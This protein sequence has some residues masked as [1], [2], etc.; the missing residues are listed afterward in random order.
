MRR[1]RKKKK[2][3]LRRKP[4]KILVS[5]LESLRETKKIDLQKTKGFKKKKKPKRR[6]KIKILNSF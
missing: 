3:K 1:K 5:L 2:K 6:R 4:L